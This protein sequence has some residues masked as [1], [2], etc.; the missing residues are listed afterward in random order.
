MRNDSFV[1][2]KGGGAKLQQPISKHPCRTLNKKSSRK[3]R[4][5]DT[6]HRKQRAEHTRGGDLGGSGV[7]N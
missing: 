6:R 7:K 3:A 2:W 1:Q 4:Q 5:Q